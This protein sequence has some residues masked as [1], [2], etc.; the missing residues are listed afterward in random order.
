MAFLYQTTDPLAHSRREI[1]IL[2][3]PI[4]VTFESDIQLLHHPYDG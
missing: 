3:I 1:R 2:S 4:A